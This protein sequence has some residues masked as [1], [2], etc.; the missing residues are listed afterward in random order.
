MLDAQIIVGVPG[1][2]AG[3]GPGDQLPT[4]AALSPENQVAFKQFSNLSDA[5][6]TF[7][8]ATTAPTP[9]KYPVFFVLHYIQSDS[10]TGPPPAA[11]NVSTVMGQIGL[12]SVS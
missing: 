5:T 11:G 9:G 8:F 4:T 10:C 12:L 6:Q 2:T 3:V 7:S 1:S